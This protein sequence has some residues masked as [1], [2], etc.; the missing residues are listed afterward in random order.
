M[1]CPASWPKVRIEQW[2]AMLKSRAIE[3]LAYTI[4]INR[5]GIDGYKLEYNGES[6]VFNPI[7]EEQEF[8]KS[9]PYL[10]QTEISME[11]VPYFREKYRSEEH[12]SE[13]QIKQ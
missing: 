10:L 13:L 6:K 11:T 5:T 2:K 9:N 8:L 4:G 12:T 3:N 1:I 7:G